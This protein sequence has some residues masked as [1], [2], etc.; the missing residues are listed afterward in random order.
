MAGFGVREQHQGVLPA[1]SL[2]GRWVVM[3]QQANCGERSQASLSI[4]LGA[5]KVDFKHRG[6][7]TS[8][9]FPMMP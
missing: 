2:K 4:A 6:L 5:T 7:G 9:N 3:A 8:N 1:V